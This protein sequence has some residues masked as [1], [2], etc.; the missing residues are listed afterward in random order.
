MRYILK[1]FLLFFVFILSG[2]KIGGIR[3]Q[4]LPKDRLIASKVPRITV[5]VHGTNTRAIIPN[6]KILSKLVETDLRPFD[7]FRKNSEYYV[8]ANCLYEADPVVFPLTG[9]YLFRWTGLLNYKERERAAGI[10]YELLA[11]EAKKVELATGKKPIVTIIAHSHGGNV[12]LNMA[13]VN[14]KSSCNLKIDR[15]ILLACP[16]Q[17][18]TSCLSSHCIFKKI[19]SFYS[20]LDLI[21]V[22]AL[23]KGRKLAGRRFMS[24]DNTAQIRTRWKSRGLFHNDFKHVKFLKFLPETLRA[25]DE[26]CFNRGNI[27]SSDYLLSI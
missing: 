9:F 26:K 5:W 22:M 4:L 15:L 27:C 21:Q 25:V 24:C 19:Y 14:D 16:V 13:N 17:K 11:A 12:A 10:L 3:L 23:Q 2:C 18:R 20:T 7:K 1:S 6:K 8:R